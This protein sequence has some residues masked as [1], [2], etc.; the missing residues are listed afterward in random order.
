MTG[1]SKVTWPPLL[2]YLFSLVEKPTLEHAILVYWVLVCCLF[3]SP[4]PGII[5][6]ACS[7]CS[8]NYFQVWHFVTPI[9]ARRIVYR[10]WWHVSTSVDWV[11]PLGQRSTILWNLSTKVLTD[12]SFFCL[13]ARRV[14]TEISI[15][16]SKKRARNK[17]LK[18]GPCLDQAGR[19]F[20]EPFKGEPL[21]A[22]MNK[23]AIIVSFDI[24]FLVWDLK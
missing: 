24:T 2:K 22:P 5:S 14:I 1:V 3:F 9:W 23:W 4:D 16:S 13:V 15:L 18:V 17:L 7:P 6:S 11:M 10:L 12:S 20:H 19:K 21:R 8:T